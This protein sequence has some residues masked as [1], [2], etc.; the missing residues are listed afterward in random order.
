MKYLRVSSRRSFSQSLFSALHGV[1][2]V[3]RGGANFR[4]QLFIFIIV[5]VLAFVLQ[6]HVWEVL[7]IIFVSAA[8]MSFEAINSALEALEDIVHVHHHPAIRHSKDIAAGAVVI[9]SVAA[10]LIGIFLFGPRLYM[11]LVG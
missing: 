2:L 10:A 8:V 9:M 6:L 5:L 3:V 11:L 4:R 7:I 1:W